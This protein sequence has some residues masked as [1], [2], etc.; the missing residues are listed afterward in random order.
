MKLLNYLCKDES[1]SDS[2]HES[3]E[4]VKLRTI[5]DLNGG[6][7]SVGSGTHGDL[8]ICGGG[9][10]WIHERNALSRALLATS[11]KNR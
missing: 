7:K 1:D 3:H 2:A 6:N 4:G 5:C 9:V 11:V 8:A 10:H